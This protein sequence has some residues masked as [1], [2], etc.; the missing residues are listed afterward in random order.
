MEY[1][2]LR[3]KWLPVIRAD[4][5]H[6]FI[7]PCEIAGGDSPPVDLVPP[8]P[9]FRAA[10][11]EFLIGLIQTACPPQKE[12]DWFGRIDEPM[13]P[14]ELRAA[15]EPFEQY[16]ICSAPGHVSCRT[17]PCPTRTSLP[18]TKSPPCS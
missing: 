4:G 3:E 9:D 5:S 18:E 7:S 2:L 6:D 1:N 10:L 17:L 11:M 14:D 8:R 15:M 12:Q 13:T 16:F